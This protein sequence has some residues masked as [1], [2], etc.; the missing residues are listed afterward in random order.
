MRLKVVVNFSHRLV[1]YTDD[2]IGYS[3]KASIPTISFHGSYLLQDVPKAA[4]RSGHIVL[5]E[6]GE[7][8]KI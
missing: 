6:A 8:K 5:L 4:S 2:E 7:T 3:F 1:H